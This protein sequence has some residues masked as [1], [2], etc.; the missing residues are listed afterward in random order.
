MFHRFHGWK[1]RG[2]ERIQERASYAA[3]PFCAMSTQSLPSIA[4]RLG[5]SPL[6]MSQIALF[7]TSVSLILTRKSTDQLLIRV[8]DPTQEAFL[9]AGSGLVSLSYASNNIIIFVLEIELHD[10]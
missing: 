3:L 4:M 9:A 10:S 7:R 2:R 5:M 1:V 8:P 6:N